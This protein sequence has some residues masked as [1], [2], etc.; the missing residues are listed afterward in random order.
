MGFSTEEV[1]AV[2]ALP[3][4][5]TA[6]PEGTRQSEPGFTEIVFESAAEGKHH[7]A[8]VDGRLAAVT[9]SP[10]DRV[11]IAPLAEHAVSVVEVVSV[12]AEDRL[13]DFGASLSGYGDAQGARAELTWSGGRYLDDGLDH[14]DVYGGPVGEI[15]T[16]A[17]LNAEPIPATV[18]GANLGGFGCGG[19]G[20]GGWG[21][22]AMRFTFVTA[23]Y[24]PGTYAF[25]VVA[26]DASGNTVGGQAAQVEV[27]LEGLVRPPSDLAVAAYDGQTQTA[28]LAWTA[29]AD[30]VA[31]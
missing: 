25:E 13:T 21:R 28:T 23:K 27:A 24:F 7:Q 11:M 16:S 15:D 10:E 14:F 3:V 1:T 17:P 30:L 2:R 20:R 6:G 8:Y 5:L 29:S 22:S 12:D 18:G 4:V 9:L 31:G 26:V 19:F